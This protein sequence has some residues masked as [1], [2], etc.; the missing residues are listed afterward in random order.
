MGGIGYTQ[1]ME[2]RYRL[3]FRGEVL[4]GQHAAVV[5]KKLA[6]ALG[7]KEEAKV[8]H[9]FSGKAVVIRKDSDTKTAAKFQ[10]A[11]KNSGARLRVMPV[12]LSM[13]ELEAK[14]AADQAKAEQDRLERERAAALA[15]MPNQA[16]FD[17]TSAWA[18]MPAGSPVLADEERE[19]VEPAEV[20]TDHLRLETTTSFGVV[21]AEEE[22]EPVEIQ[23]PDFDVAAVGAVIGPAADADTAD[24]SDLL[25]EVDFSVA[26]PGVELV[27]P[28]PPVEVPVEL[29]ESE[30]DL[31]EPGADMG[32][33]TEEQ[34]PPPAPD[35]SH[36][37][38]VAEAPQK[39]AAGS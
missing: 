33:D 9:L 26:E 10:A 21:E 8:E 19:E 22:A 38:M 36:L 6:Q 17:D 15:A 18:L 23:A 20:A 31:A 32:E 27:Q 24:A 28:S 3:V 14:E 29:L 16:D 37:E 11:F 12:V 34:I 13:E 7:I 5:K 30:F 25:A 1:G 2:E 39:S 35:V 4:D